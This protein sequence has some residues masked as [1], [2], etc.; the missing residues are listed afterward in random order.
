MSSYAQRV[1]SRVSTLFVELYGSFHFLMIVSIPAPEVTQCYFYN[2]LTDSTCI[3]IPYLY[4]YEDLTF[5][6]FP[7]KNS[8]HFFKHI[9]HFQFTMES[10]H[11]RQILSNNYVCHCIFLYLFWFECFLFVCFCDYL[12][13]SKSLWKNCSGIE[14]NSYHQKEY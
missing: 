11:T 6:P 9:F 1:G 7:W 14:W 12:F 4:M 2:Y 3:H 13:A 5:E 8:Q 10:N